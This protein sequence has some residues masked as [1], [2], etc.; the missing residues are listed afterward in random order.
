MKIESAD[1]ND[2]IKR[3][4][5]TEGSFYWIG[6][7]DSVNEGDWKWADGTAL[8]GFMNWF[9]NEPNNWKDQDCGAISHGQQQQ[10]DGAF[11]DAQWRDWECSDVKGFICEK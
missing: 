11:F 8:T 7:T 2:F 6:L 5:L 1:E 4:Y 3:K 10:L 9:P